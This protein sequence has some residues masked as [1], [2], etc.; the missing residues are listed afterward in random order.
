MFAR[1]FIDSLDFAHKGQELRGTAPVSEMTRLQDMLAAPDGEVG[2]VLRG[3]MGKDGKPLL[4]L[5]LT[6]NCQLRCQRCLQGMPYA[7]NTVS[8]L[9]PVPENELES[10]SME[11]GEL[12]EADGIDR[13]PADAHLDVLGLVEDEILLGL[14]LS[15]RH[16]SGACAAAAESVPAGKQNPFAVLRE[17][18]N[19]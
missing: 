11:G 16:E 3:L 1:H 9:M 6:G 19:K 10:S 8:L 12:D 4:E 7:I 14:P 2:Y 17:L 5:S 13:I 15:P 18:K